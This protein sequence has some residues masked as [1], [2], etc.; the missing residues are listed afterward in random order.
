MTIHEARHHNPA[1]AINRFGLALHGFRFEYCCSPHANDLGSLRQDGSVREDPK[2]P[3]IAAATRDWWTGKSENLPGMAEK[4][5][6][7]T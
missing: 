4:K 3:K 1:L 7:G 2:F 5:C 6:R